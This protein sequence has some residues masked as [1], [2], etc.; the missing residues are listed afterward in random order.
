MANAKQQDIDLAI[1]RYEYGDLDRKQSAV[2]TIETSKHY[3]G[4]LRSSAS[5][6]WVGNRMRSHCFSLCGDSGDFGRNRLMISAPSVKATQKAIDKQ[7][8]EVFTPDAVAV[9]VEAAKA[10]YA[11][12]VRAGVD[13]FRNTYP[14]SLPV[15]EVA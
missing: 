4:G 9:L 11:A 3:I 8:A 15:A 7:H 2:L 10:H 14:A 12:V 5:V 13:G 6:Y 1:T